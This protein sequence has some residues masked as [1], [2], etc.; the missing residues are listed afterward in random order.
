M[1]L[2]RCLAGPTSTSMALL[3]DAYRAAPAEPGVRSRLALALMLTGPLIHLG[4]AWAYSP[5]EGVWVGPDLAA[6]RRRPG[7]SADAF[8]CELGALY[9]H[10][11]AVAVSA[12]G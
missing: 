8:D 9:G 10:P 6:H 1:V 7:L 11:V 2:E 4:R 12:P 5:D 3:I